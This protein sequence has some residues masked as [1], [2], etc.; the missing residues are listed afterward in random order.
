M[1]AEKLRKAVL[2]AAIRGKLTQQL[3]EDGDARDLLKQ[4]WQEKK[5]LI[6]EGKLRKV[7]PVPTVVEDEVPFEIPEN[8]VWVR[9][10]D[11][12]SIGSAKRIHQRDWRPSG[13]P[14]YRAR[15]IAKLSESG[16]VDNELYIDKHYYDEI[17]AAFGVPQP[18][19]LMVTG[20]GTL[21][22]TYIVKEGDAF[23]Y[24]DASVLCLSNYGKIEAEFIKL[25]MQ[26]QTMKD[27]IL[28]NSSG[29]TVAT[30]TISRF[31]N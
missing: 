18:G 22:K 30:L 25:Y 3:S 9:F 1:I 8:W 12:F 24:K 15:E 2:Q 11:V 6:K 16:A 4:I 31:D 21:G 28:S 26:S 19:D 29:T 10:G 5:Q 14:F 20:V 27:Q 13:I 23:Y 17:K 7:K